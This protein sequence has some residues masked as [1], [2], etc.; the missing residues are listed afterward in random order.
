METKHRMSMWL[1]T[2]MFL[3]F[4]FSS[5]SI[6]KDLSIGASSST[7]YST[8]SMHI[9]R[10]KISHYYITSYLTYSQNNY[11][12]LELHKYNKTGNSHYLSKHTSYLLYI[13]NFIVSPLKVSRKF[14]VRCTWSVQYAF[15]NLPNC[16]RSRRYYQWGKFL[17]QN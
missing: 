11:G 3:T 12:I 16:Y 2:C 4:V 10:E 8:R 13:V 7:P 5:C 15:S 9:I 17:R 14:P 6:S 1:L